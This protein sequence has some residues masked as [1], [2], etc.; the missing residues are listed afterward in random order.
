MLNPVLSSGADPG[1]YRGMKIP[2]KHNRGIQ[3]TDVTS[4]GCNPDLLFEGSTSILKPLSGSTPEVMVT[5]WPHYKYTQL[6]DC[7]FFSTQTTVRVTI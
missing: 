6:W 2:L 5:I 4:R 1:S 7:S 3:N